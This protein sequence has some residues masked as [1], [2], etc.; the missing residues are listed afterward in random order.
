[1]KR[2]RRPL[3]LIVILLLAGAVVNVAV[4]WGCAITGQVL[5]AKGKGQSQTTFPR[6]RFPQV[7]GTESWP[8]T[9]LNDS[10][11]WFGSDQAR[12]LSWDADQSWSLTVFRAGWPLRSVVSYSGWRH[13][14]TTASSQFLP[15]TPSLPVNCLGYSADLPLRP[16]SWPFL[17]NTLLYAAIVALPLFF[18]LRRH[19][20]R[21]RGHC[22]RCNY[23]L[24][25]INGPCP[26]CGATR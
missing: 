21:R 18:P 9:M 7:S 15:E 25:G 23:D 26:E 16:R 4:A 11:T 8:A 17:L 2:W 3:I 6:L 1:M 13:S 10:V 20:R 22:P 5:E 14:K 24:E 19:I 12:Y